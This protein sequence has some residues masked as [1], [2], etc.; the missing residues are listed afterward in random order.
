[1]APFEAKGTDFWASGQAWDNRC[2]VKGAGERA[3]E[4]YSL[5]DFGPANGLHCGLNM[6]DSLFCEV[7]EVNGAEVYQTRLRPQLQR[8]ASRRQL[9]AKLIKDHS[10]RTFS[11]PRRRKDRNPRAALM[12]P[13]PGSTVLCLSRYIAFPASVDSRCRICSR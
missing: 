1:M 4:P 5:S 2:K 9:N 3:G 11:R 8:R 12:M 6:S 13:K 10:V 7:R